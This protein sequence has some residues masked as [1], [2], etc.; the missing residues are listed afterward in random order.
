MDTNEFDRYLKE[1]VDDQF[2]YFDTN[3]KRNQ[4]SYRR[5]KVAAISRV[6]HHSWW[7]SQQAGRP[8]RDCPSIALH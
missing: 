7:E 8:F 5:L 3:A 2:G 6:A 1:R 4:K